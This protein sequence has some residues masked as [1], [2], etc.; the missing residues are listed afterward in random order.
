MNVR[1]QQ[2]A[3]AAAGF[4]PGPIDGIRG[5]KTVAA[6]KAFQG[7]RGL[8]VDG[9]VGP[10]TTAAL[11]GGGGGG[12]AAP[13]AAAGAPAINDEVLA[14]NYGFAM[15]VLNSDSEL[16]G[17]FQRAVGETWT[18]D[19]FQ[20]QLRGTGWY[21]KHSEQW[22][23]TEL[24]RTT[25]PTSYQA[26]LDQTR[27]RVQM[28]ASELGASGDVAA[29]GEQAY[30]LGWDD[31]QIRQSLSTYIQYTDGRMIGQAGQW[32]Q[33]LRDWAYDNGMTLSDSFYQTHI[34]SATRGTQT[35]D[36]VKRAITNMAISAFPHLG[37]R[38]RAGDTLA[39]IADP[40]KQTMAG[41][42]EVNPNSISMQ[43]PA[44]KG[45][46]AAKDKTGAPALRTL[47]DF[48]NDI[49]GDKRWLGTKNA[50]DAATATTSR[51][52]KDF[53]LIT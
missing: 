38:L 4:D 53:G 22:R 37:D 9:I 40:Y 12:E 1:A 45:A 13:A 49:R 3:L 52:L 43:D 10:Q 24:L 25:D 26:K 33:D 32:N 47:Y 29:I 44:I 8:A 30:R 7:A 2:Q 15:A 11:G 16:K 34:A 23:N 35:I 17:L 46:L 41:L 5:R 51:V 19:K 36:D 14:Q 6:I 18:A 50:Q 20:A 21:Q 31:N 28:M 42:L 39:T 48:E 27:V